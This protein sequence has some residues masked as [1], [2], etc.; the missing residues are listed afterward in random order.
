MA[1]QFRAVVTLPT[2][3]KF[4][5]KEGTNEILFMVISVLNGIVPVEVIEAQDPIGKL[6]IGVA[7]D[8]I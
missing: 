8:S 4:K 3:N 2:D 6:T 1:Q 7:N 5:R